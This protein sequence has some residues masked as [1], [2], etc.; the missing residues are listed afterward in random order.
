MDERN[1][2]TKPLLWRAIVKTFWPEYLL[3]GML[4]LIFDIIA[5]ITLPFLLKNL[6]EYFRYVSFCSLLFLI[7]NSRTH[8][9]WIHNKLMYSEKIPK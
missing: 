8:Q 9:Y 3:T 1:G 6:L 7:N 4:N 5:P 2:K